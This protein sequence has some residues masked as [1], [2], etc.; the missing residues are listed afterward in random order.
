MLLR[1]RQTAVLLAAVVAGL[2]TQSF[3]ADGYGDLTGRIIFDGDV[4]KL[5]P[6]INKNNP[7]AKLPAC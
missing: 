2:T 3:A 7:A 6:K 5:L 4:P 1:F